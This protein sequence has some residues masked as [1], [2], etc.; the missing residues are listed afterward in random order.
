MDIRDL[1]G[2]A[3]SVDR[4]LYR[5]DFEAPS[6]RPYAFAYFI[7]IH[8]Q[9]PH[10]VTIKGRKWVVTDSSGNRIVV[11]GDGVVG[12]FPRLLPGQQFSYSSHHVIAAHSYAEGAYIGMTDSG[13]AV[14][15]KIPRFEMHIPG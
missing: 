6:D 9:S 10:T 5:P 12:Q 2:L 7:T 14:I 4:V 3:V 13:Q 15:T 11:E 1:P 8:N